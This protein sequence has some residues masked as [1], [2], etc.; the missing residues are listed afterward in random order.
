[1]RAR[2][3]DWLGLGVSPSGGVQLKTQCAD[4]FEDRIET[5]T[6]ITGEGLV[7]AFP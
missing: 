2:W 5:R 7:E 1:M 4:H 3:G 6:A